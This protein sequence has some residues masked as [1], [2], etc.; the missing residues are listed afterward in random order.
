MSQT[1][2]NPQTKYYHKDY[3]FQEQPIP[4][5]QS[6]MTPVPD[7]GET[8]YPQAAKAKVSLRVKLP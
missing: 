4:G 6:K 2:H 7:C 3:P 5:L 8:S 1:P